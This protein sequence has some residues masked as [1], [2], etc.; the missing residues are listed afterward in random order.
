M[1]NRFDMWLTAGARVFIA[2][3]LMYL[4]Y[5]LYTIFRLK[6][7]D[8]V[9]ADFSQIGIAFALRVIAVTVTIIASFACVRQYRSRKSIHRSSLLTAVLCGICMVGQ[10]FF[11]ISTVKPE[12]SDYPMLSLY[13]WEDIR[14]YYFIE[15]IINGSMT[16]LAGLVMMLVGSVSLF[17][18]EKPY[19]EPFTYTTW[20]D[21]PNRY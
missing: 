11:M 3:Q 2:G 19:A 1:K 12:V 4:M 9:I 20:E 17:R 10:M 18:R 21:N 14:L 5:A 7:S 6:N 15:N 13:N 16:Q 8:E